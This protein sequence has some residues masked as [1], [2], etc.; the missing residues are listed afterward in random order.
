[1]AA[2]PSRKAPNVSATLS[3]DSGFPWITLRSVNIPLVAAINNLGTWLSAIDAGL[4]IVEEADGLAIRVQPKAGTSRTR[5]E[6]FIATKK[7]AS[8][9]SGWRVKWEDN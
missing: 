9:Q 4:E 7:L 3:G 6:L 8:A 1:M 2:Q 5:S